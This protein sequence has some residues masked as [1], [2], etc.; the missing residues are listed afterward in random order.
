MGV[1]K[2]WLEVYGE[3]LNFF[4]YPNSFAYDQH[5]RQL[6]VDFPYLFESDDVINVEALYCIVLGLNYS[7]K[8]NLIIS[9]V[10]D[11]ILSNKPSQI[12]N[13]VKKKG[14]LIDDKDNRAWTVDS[15]GNFQH[16]LSI[17]PQI[18]GNSQIVLDYEQQAIA[19]YSPELKGKRIKFRSK[20]CYFNW[21]EELP[22]KN[23]LS[24]TV[25]VIRNKE[26]N[27]NMESYQGVVN[28]IDRSRVLDPIQTLQLKDVELI[29]NIAI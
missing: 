22:N 4:G 27:R 12:S 6:S 18:K 29:R 17:V 16:G 26:G 15:S 24:I 11:A 13:Y 10:L 1:E 19:D 5:S 23:P 25:H 7:I 2:I 14:K 9:Q 28:P 20:V 21:V 3:P 8:N